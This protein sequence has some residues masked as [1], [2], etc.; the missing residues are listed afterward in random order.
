M[1]GQ[2]ESTTQSNPDAGL[3]AML[4]MLATIGQILNCGTSVCCS[5]SAIIGTP[6]TMGLS[7]GALVFSRRAHATAQESGEGEAAALTGL[8]LGAINLLIS[9][10]AAAFALM[11]LL[12][13]VGAAI[14]AQ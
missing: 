1:S 3:G 6:I 13:I 12:V 9:L 4:G 10:V 5:F 8:I 7:I 14:G 2:F 11:T